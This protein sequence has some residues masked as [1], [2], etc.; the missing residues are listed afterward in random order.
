LTARAVEVL[1]QAVSDPSADYRQRVTL[2]AVLNVRESTSYA[3]R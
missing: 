3:R 1:M 2:E